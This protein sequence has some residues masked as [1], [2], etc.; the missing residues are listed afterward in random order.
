MY[1]HCEP[2]LYSFDIFIE[3]ILGEKVGERKQNKTNRS[4]PPPAVQWQQNTERGRE[5]AGALELVPRPPGTSPLDKQGQAEDTAH[6]DV[7]GRLWNTCD[8]KRRWH[9]ASSRKS[10]AWSLLSPFPPHQPPISTLDT[11]RRR[12]H[13]AQAKPQQVGGQPGFPREQQLS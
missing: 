11:S 4:A 10:E 2:Q 13:S 9:E 5:A 7:L 6:E 1:V 8:R 12:S 3:K